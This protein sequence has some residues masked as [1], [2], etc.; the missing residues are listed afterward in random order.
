MT[1]EEAS[2]ILKMLLGYLKGEI[3]PPKQETIEEARAFEQQGYEC[4]EMAIKALEPEPCEDCRNCKKWDECLCGKEGHENGT[5]KG[6]SIGE[7]KDYEPCEDFIS[8]QAVFSFIRSLTRWCVKSEDGKFHNIGLLYDD[9]MFGIDKLP[10]ITP[11]EKTDW[12]PVSERLP[13]E[14]ETDVLVCCETGAITVCCG[15]YSTEVSNTFIWYT[16]GWRY[17]KVVAWMPLP[18][19]YKVGDT[20][21]NG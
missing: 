19:P 11:K 20:D 5:S 14:E 15:S 3:E 4:L 10:S 21:G 12:I 17:G 6:Y 18:E 2:K 16:G 8:R 7:C 9:V 13:E 1:V